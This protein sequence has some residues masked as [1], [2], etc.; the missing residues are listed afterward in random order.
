VLRSQKVGVRLA[1]AFAAAA[2][3]LIIVG[4]LDLFAVS[5]LL[6]G[7]RSVTHTYQVLR[8]VD[9][10]TSSLKDAETSQRGFLITG[11]DAYLQP[12]GTPRAGSPVRSTRWPA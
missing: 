8:A 6:Q 5:H 4:V 9:T 7:Q 10:V 3:M 2:A 11:N 1:A 12:T